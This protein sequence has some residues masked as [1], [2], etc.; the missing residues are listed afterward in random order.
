MNRVQ[1]REAKR[2]R[3]EA[4][5]T[6]GK[7]TVGT[8]RR[9]VKE[10]E[11]AVDAMRMNDELLAQR[12]HMDKEYDRRH[13]RRREA[14]AKGVRIRRER[15]RPATPNKRPPKGYTGVGPGRPKR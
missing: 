8:R 12:T 14:L 2:K 5:K 3:R 1:R 9:R 10:A 13:A 11:R 6:R 7:I 15:W 4:R